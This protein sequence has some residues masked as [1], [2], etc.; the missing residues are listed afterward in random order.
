MELNITDTEDGK[1]E[2]KYETTTI[3]QTKVENAYKII[4][5]YISNGNIF[6]FTRKDLEIKYKGILSESAIRGAINKLLEEQK[7]KAEGNTKVRKFIVQNI[8]SF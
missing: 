1:V 7:I 3:S 4:W 8:L 5:Q 2:I 6:E